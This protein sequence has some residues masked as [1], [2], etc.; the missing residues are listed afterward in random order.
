M[1]VENG[2]GAAERPCDPPVKTLPD[3]VRLPDTEYTCRLRI[4]GSALDLV[5]VDAALDLQGEHGH[6][7]RRA[8]QRRDAVNLCRWQYPKGEGG[9][10]TYRI[11]HSL[12]DALRFSVKGLFPVRDRLERYV[13]SADVYWWIGCFHQAPSSLIY[14]PHDLLDQLAAIGAPTYFDNY[15]SSSYEAGVDENQASE[16]EDDGLPLHR[17]RFWIDETL[18]SRGDYLARFASLP[19]HRG[20]HGL[21]SGHRT[22]YRLP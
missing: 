2:V 20:R 5:A 18:G 1:S 12:E 4:D 13:A 17:Y 10:G 11:W 14:L 3:D 21:R 6:V 22:G 9:D 7:N 15:F 19:P 8:T 16:V